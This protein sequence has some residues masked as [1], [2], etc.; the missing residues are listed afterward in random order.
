MIGQ[1][2]YELMITGL[3]G[4]SRRYSKACPCRIFSASAQNSL[5][6]V[7]A[8]TCFCTF[9]SVLEIE[10]RAWGM[11]GKRSVTELQPQPSRNIS[12]IGPCAYNQ[13]KKAGVSLW[14]LYRKTRKIRIFLVLL[15]VLRRKIAE[16]ILVSM[17]LAGLPLLPIPSALLKIH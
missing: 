4:P 12:G 5:S 8:E 16:G 1:K 6:Q 11:L 2:E 14:L 15:S 3:V 17:A 9:P 10:A 7:A 13:I